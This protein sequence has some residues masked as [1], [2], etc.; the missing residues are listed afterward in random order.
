MPTPNLD[1]TPLAAA[2]S[3]KHVTVNE[4]FAR[5]DAAAQPTVKDRTQATPPQSPE[6]GDRH[7]IAEGASGDWLDHEDDIAAWDAAGQNWIFLTPR[8]GWQVWVTGEQK[9]LRY[10]GAVWKSETLT[11]LGVN[12]APDDI[13]RLAVASEAILLTHEGAGI[14]TKLNKATAADTASILFQTNYTGHA[15]IGLTGGTD[16]QFKTSPDGIAFNDAMTLDAATGAA[17][18]PVPATV[19][20]LSVSPDLALNILPD[21]GRFGGESVNV[22]LIAPSFVPPTYLRA[23]NGSTL[24]GYARFI[25]GNTTYGGSSGALDPEID[26]LLSI[27]RVPT[28]RRHG[29]EWW[30][31]KVIMGDRT[32]AN[33]T[34]D[35]VTRYPAFRTINVP[36]P[37]A[38]TVGFYVRVLN[39]SALIDQDFTSR[40]SRWG[41]DETGNL[42]SGIIEPDDGWVFIERQVTFNAFGYNAGLFQIYLEEDGDEALIA[43][44]RVTVGHMTLDPYLPGPL[45][46][47][48]CFG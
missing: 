14:Q 48:R 15:E 7:L 30:A 13:N 17:T 39:G 36:L 3:Q 47:A 29:A 24:E 6:D 38:L 34:V 44:P 26:G 20:G 42:D 25:H 41:A 1:L 40:F 2:Q 8:N 32:L 22:G 27:L 28:R 19:S 12:A 10:D 33:V 9:M 45:P 21:Q 46:N 23:I 4:A 5:L 35:G 37:R 16:L 31:M 11:Q 43:M 18:F